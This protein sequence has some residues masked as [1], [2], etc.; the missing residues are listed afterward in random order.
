MDPVYIAAIAGLAL[1]FAFAVGILF[2]V[3]KTEIE[4]SRYHMLD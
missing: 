2:Y 4:A 3:C 1:V